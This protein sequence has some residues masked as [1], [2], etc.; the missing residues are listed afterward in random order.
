MSTTT[1]TSR[2]TRPRS[3]YVWVGV[4]IL[5]ICLM[6]GTFFY[7]TQKVEYIWRWNRLPI[8]F[9]YQDEIEIISDIDGEIES[10]KTDGDEAVI[11]VKGLDGVES[12]IAPA[13]SVKVDVG[14]YI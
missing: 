11:T 14:G 1:N 13:D 9:L 3:Y 12:Y 8:Y 7:T 5:V 6:A 10:V 4:F 2:F